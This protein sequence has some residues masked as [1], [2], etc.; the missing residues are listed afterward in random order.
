MSALRA[1]KEKL[2]REAFELA[3]QVELGKVNRRTAEL[4]IQRVTENTPPRRAK[5]GAPP[6]GHPPPPAPTPAR[7]E[8]N[9]PPPRAF[10]VGIILFGVPPPAFSPPP[11]PGGARGRSGRSLAW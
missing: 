10:F 8:I 5:N 2:N 4:E 6:P 7:P 3:K 11:P 1:E 9:R